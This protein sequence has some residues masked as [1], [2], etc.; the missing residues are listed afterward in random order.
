M[1]ALFLAAAVFAASELG[2]SVVA[3]SAGAE[4]SMVSGTV[5]FHWTLGPDESGTAVYAVSGPV[6]DVVAR[7]KYDPPQYP[8]G[9]RRPVNWPMYLPATLKSFSY[10][11]T[12]HNDCADGTSATTTLTAD[13]IVN[14]RAVLS[15]DAR[16]SLNVLHKRGTGALVPDQ[17]FRWLGGGIVHNSDLWRGL[18][19]VTVVQ[20]GTPCE[21]DRTPARQNIGLD[22]LIPR[23]VRIDWSVDR[24]LPLRALSG[25]WGL[26]GQWRSS[27]DGYTAEL[28]A[29]LR[30]VGPLRGLG[31]DCVWP[32]DRDLAGARSV[33]QA[34]ATLK[35][36]GLVTSYGGAK[37][38]AYVP[39][40]HYYIQT[41]GSEWPCG[42]PGTKALYLSRGR[43]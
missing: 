15:H 18:G 28:K 8:A 23:D 4:A 19:S 22:S 38:N 39:K 9:Y 21:E 17:R 2:P 34:Q 36:A 33:A 7:E 24:P 27:G 43:L 13:G 40:G 37:A 25:G 12:Q 5:T 20:A 31:A 41:G 10:L 1:L 29:D 26:K 16:L 11:Q 14:A 35:R 42:V 3:A 6:M 30:F 32:S